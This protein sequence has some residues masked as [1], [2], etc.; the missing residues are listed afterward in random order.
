[1]NQWKNASIINRNVWHKVNRLPKIIFKRVLINI[2]HL[3]VFLIKTYFI[4]L[5]NNIF[6]CH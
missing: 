6:M 5:I 3:K 4:L 1:M 2:A